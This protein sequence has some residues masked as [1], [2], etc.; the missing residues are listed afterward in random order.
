MKN[1]NR[2]QKAIS[3]LL[4]CFFIVVNNSG[5]YAQQNSWTEKINNDG[6][7]SLA[8]EPIIWNIWPGQSPGKVKDL[9]PEYDTTKPDGDL[10]AG[11]RVIRLTNV[12]VPQIAIF[13][14]DPSSDTK[15]SIIIAPGGGHWILAYDLEGT[16]IAEWFNSI[17]DY[18]HNSK[19][20]SSRKGME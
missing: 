5:M 13:K 3:F 18:G 20:Q 16:E 11:R 6:T 15:T 12:S 8:V 2:I 19:V 10:V 17:R 7:S 14:P 1:R 4:I 9:E